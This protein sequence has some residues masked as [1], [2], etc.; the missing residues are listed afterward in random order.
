MR[1]AIPTDGRGGLDDPVAEHFGRC[2]TYTILDD[3]GN[4]LEVVKNTSEHMGGKGLPP[5]IMK[6]NGADVLL[7]MGIGPRAISLCKELGIEVYVHRAKNVREIFR[8]W[9]D[10]KIK[11]AGMED[12][13]GEHGI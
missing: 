13:C 6:E 2:E 10:G 5:Q 12:V 3:D 7:C 8:L 11:K 4:V 9:K 1:I